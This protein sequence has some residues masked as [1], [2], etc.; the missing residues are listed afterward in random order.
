MVVKNVRPCIARH[1]SVTPESVSLSRI[2]TGKFN[3]S[4]YV[5]AGQREMV[6]R[7]A[8]SDDTFCLFYEKNMMKQEPGIHAM[9][10]EKTSIPVPRIDV[11]DDTREYLDR[12][13][14]LMERLPGEPLSQS[15]GAGF[16]EVLRSIGDCLRQAHSLT[17]EQYGY[18]GEH[19][20]MEPQPTWTDAFVIMWNRLIDDVVRT[21]LYSDKEASY[22][23][24]LLETNIRS[25]DRPVQSSLLHM[26]VWAQ[27]ILVSQDGALTGLI[28]WDRTL[29]GDPEIEFAVLDYCGMSEPAFWEGYGGE[30]DTSEDAMIRRAFYLLYE[31]QKYIPIRY[32]R[33]NSPSTARSYKEQVMRFVA[34]AFR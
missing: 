28:D 12:D 19:R 27:N 11:Y 15:V 2:P 14:L 29:W 7:I 20:P 33:G 3:D 26:D 21:G 8:P 6:V 13:F 25:F 16:Q 34:T 23:R 18:L 9:L 17:A 31:L 30:R 1:L 24:E 22:M 4:Y 5:T 10:R 32:L